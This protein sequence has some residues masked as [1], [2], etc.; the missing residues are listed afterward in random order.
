MESDGKAR[1][2][3]GKPKESEK[4]SFTAIRTKFALHPENPERKRR[5]SK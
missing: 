3:N 2:D 4:I 5:E 1:E